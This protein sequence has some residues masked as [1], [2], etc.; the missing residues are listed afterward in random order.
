[1]EEFTQSIDLL[2]ERLGG[3]ALLASDEFFA[4]KE[5]LVRASEPTFLADAYTERGKLMDGWESRRKRTPGFD[6]CILRLGLPGIVRGV[7]VDTA[8]FRGNFPESCSIEGCAVGPNVTPDALASPQTKW[9]ELLPR[10]T[11]RGDAKNEFRIESPWCFT[12]LRLNIFPD[13]GVARLRVHGLAMPDWKRVSRAGL[14]LDLAALEHGSKLVATNDRF[15]GSAQNM[16]M[17]GAST[18]MGDG[19]ETRRRRTPGHDWAIVR[20]AM[21][22]RVQRAEI[23]TTHFKGNYPDAASL[24]ACSAPDATVEQL[25]GDA[26]GVEWRELMPRQ[27]LQAHTSHVYE[28]ELA[29]LDETTHVRVSIHP[30]GGVARL[31]LLGVA[32]AA[33]RASA[34]L[35]GLNALAPERW[36]AE[37]L[38][39][40]G[41]TTWV[42]AMASARPY[43]TLEAIEAA[44]DRIAHELSRTDWLEAFGRHPKIGERSASGSTRAWSEQEQAGARAAGAAS[45]AELARVNAEYQKKFG[46]IFIVCAT[47]KS[48]DEMLAAA[49]ARLGNSPEA[50]LR[51]ASEEQR[52]IT[53][54]RL[55]K[56]FEGR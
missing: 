8:Y 9:I 16:L 53:R 27:K 18:H 3:A 30:D 24:E 52:K 10:A 37:L 25:T 33:G 44:S 54:L 42:D 11:L 22:G 56:L 35:C 40:C 47:G 21:R 7:V 36:K 38:E 51:N 28:R 55:A 1:M 17:P 48:A 45:V 46:F 23:D 34:V 6:W 19:W 5:N 39:C 32:S 13:G 41:S 49:K 4:P 43:P 31:R 14:E 12:H 15:F 26:A 29:Q 20:L 2:A 50:E